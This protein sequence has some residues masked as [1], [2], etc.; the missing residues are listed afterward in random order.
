MSNEE[1]KG[2]LFAGQDVE[3]QGILIKN[4]KLDYIFKEMKLDKYYKLMNMVILEVSDIF[5]DGIDIDLKDIKLFDLF[6]QIPDLNKDFIEFL[7]EFTDLKWEKGNFKDFIS[8][9]NGKRIRI[10][11]EK[12]NDIKDII[13]K[14]YAISRSEK[15][16]SDEINP[17]LAVDEETR[18]FAEEIL[19]EKKK[20]NK[21]HKGNITMMG[22]INGI[23]SKNN[24]YN[25]FNI[26][27]LTVYQLMFQY[28]GIEQGENYGYILESIYHGVY[29]TKKNNFKIED[30]H[31]ACE[32]EI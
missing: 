9:K 32:I 13:K 1:L 4:Y 25:L 16:L 3:Y 6:Y 11:E 29:D 2:L 21:K 10:T 26:W 8:Y 23:C 12:F 18:K 20:N 27:D 17:D 19:E 28:Y 30:I 14:M 31:W 24:S 22:V 15:K 5:K 7:N